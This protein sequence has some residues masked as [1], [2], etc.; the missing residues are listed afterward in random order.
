MTNYEIIRSIVDVARNAG[1]DEQAY[2]DVEMLLKGG[3]IQVCKPGLNR[4]SDCR[5]ERKIEHM[6][7]KDRHSFATNIAADVMRKLTYKVQEGGK[8]TKAIESL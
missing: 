6:T 5:L 2:T 7:E 3:N 1:T 8:F 4:A